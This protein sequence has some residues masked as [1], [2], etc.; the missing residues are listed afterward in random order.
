M[1]K[2][3]HEVRTKEVNDNDPVFTHEM[4]NETLRLIRKKG[5]NKYDFVL[6][7]GHS[8]LNALFKLFQVVW[9]KE[10]KPESWRETVIVQ[11][12]KSKD[13]PISDLENKRNIHTK[14]YIPKVFGHIVTNSIKP[15]I[16]E[17]LTPFQIGAI[18]NHRY[19]EHLFT[20][21]SGSSY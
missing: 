11:I 12:P 1:E 17:N 10:V 15:L 16:V 6:K 7:A 5:G 20:L 2:I 9:N 13:N 14:P 21:Q 4:F 3:V 18:P 19:E 8:L